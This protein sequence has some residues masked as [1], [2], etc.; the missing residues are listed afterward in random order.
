[1]DCFF[2]LLFITHGYIGW[3]P[4]SRHGDRSG[5]LFQY[6]AIAGHT[7]VGGGA[8]EGDNGEMRG[9]SKSAEADRI[10]SECSYHAEDPF[11]AYFYRG[12]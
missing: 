12:E 2:S 8:V 3:W 7:G 9:D 4:E 10:S 11:S 6:E 5:P 1:M